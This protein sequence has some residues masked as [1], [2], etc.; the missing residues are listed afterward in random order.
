MERSRRNIK[1]G[2]D[3]GIDGRLYFHDAEGGDTHQI[4]FSVKAG[5]LEAGYVRDLRGTMERENAEIGVLL[6]FDTPTRKMKSEAAAAGFYDSV[7]GKHP[8]MQLL[9]VGELLV[10]C[11]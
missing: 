2:A 8:R 11:N 1:K 5:K 3:K 9:T 7:W 4:I 10:D 6:S